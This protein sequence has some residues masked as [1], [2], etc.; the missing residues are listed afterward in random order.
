MLTGF[1]C[2]RT[3][4]IPFGKSNGFDYANK[5][6]RQN[7]QAPSATVHLPDT[8]FDYPIF[9]VFKTSSKGYL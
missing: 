2:Y 6:K 4:L 7:Y 8:F 1:R 5:D 3:I 9:A